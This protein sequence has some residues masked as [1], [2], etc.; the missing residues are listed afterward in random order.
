MAAD[1]LL[2]KGFRNFAYCGY[3]QIWWSRQ[4]C[5][6]FFART[7]QN[8]CSTAVYQ[9]PY[10]REQMSWQAEQRYLTPWLKSLE[11]PVGLM[12]CNDDR[13]QQVLEACKL[14]E[15]NVPDEV[16]VLGVDNDWLVCELSDPPLSSIVLNAEATGYQAA[17]ILDKLMKGLTVENP[18]IIVE[19]THVIT[20]QSTDILAI[21]DR[22]VA[23]A[24]RYIQENCHRIIQVDEVVDAAGIARSR[25]YQKFQETLGYSVL[26]AICLLYTSDAADE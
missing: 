24:V 9:C 14:A 13:G 5:M 19:P 12:A 23:T 6:S 16:A 17:K 7:R 18:N 3:D 2:G 4:R 26:T 1:Y 11:K 25:L 15:V 21:K 10:S 8:N 20:R 22:D